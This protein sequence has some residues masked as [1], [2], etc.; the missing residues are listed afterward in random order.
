MPA[1]LNSVA[2]AAGVSTSTASRALSGHPAVLPA[3][4]A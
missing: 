4:R 1:T 2:A 3:T